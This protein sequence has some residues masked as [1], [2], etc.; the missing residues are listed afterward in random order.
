MNLEGLFL[1]SSHSFSLTTITSK[2]LEILCV[3]FFPYKDENLTSSFP[4]RV[5]APLHV[6]CH[7]VCCSFREPLTFFSQHLLNGVLDFHD[8]ERSNGGGNDDEYGDSGDGGD[9]C[10]SGGDECSGDG[11]G[12]GT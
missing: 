5:G 1:N 4:C 2:L 9:E 10:N 11:G 3:S 8:R 7:N 12:R 6:I